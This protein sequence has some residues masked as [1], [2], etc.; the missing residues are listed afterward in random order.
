MA[1]NIINPSSTLCG[2]YNSKINLLKNSMLIEELL[3][4]ILIKLNLKY[5][6]I[7]MNDYSLL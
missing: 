7:K 4:H 5:P 2:T 3:D 1:L 6:Y